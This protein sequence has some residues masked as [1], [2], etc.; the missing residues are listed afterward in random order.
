MVDIAADASAAAVAVTVAVDW[1]FAVGVA[2]A[3]LWCAKTSA[4]ICLML[5]RANQG[6][7]IIVMSLS[8]IQVFAELHA[9]PESL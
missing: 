1:A 9:R 3:I 6:I 2:L 8:R 5:I 4:D 7:V